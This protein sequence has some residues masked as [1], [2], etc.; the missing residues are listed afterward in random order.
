MTQKIE[1]IDY[2]LIYKKGRSLY[3][4]KLLKGEYKDAIFTFGKVSFKEDKENDTCKLSFDWKLEEKPDTIKEDLEKC[5]KFA[6]YLGDLLLN[7]ISDVKTIKEENARESTDD[8]T[9][10][11]NAER[12][13]L[14]E[15]SS[16]H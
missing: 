3:S 15:D 7:I 12:G 4:I 8:H 14:P 1:D 13:V 2:K 9:K 16:S 6:N 11:T 10:N 5:K